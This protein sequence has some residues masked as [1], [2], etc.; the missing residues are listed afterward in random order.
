MRKRQTSRTP[1]SSLN[2]DRILT[3]TPRLAV[4]KENEYRKKNVAPSHVGN[5]F[6]L[7]LPSLPSDAELANALK[8]IR[9][10]EPSH[11]KLRPEKRILRLGGVYKLLVPDARQISLARALWPLLIE[12]Y[13]N[14]RP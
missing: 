13:V 12:G 1:P 14:R 3:R 6:I 8:H 7:A 2:C 4:V 9:P 5:P 11:K 10:F